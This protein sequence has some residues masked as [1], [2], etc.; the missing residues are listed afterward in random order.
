M[1]DMECLLVVLA[2]QS[3][4]ISIVKNVLK[5]N[6]LFVG[7]MLSNAKLDTTRYIGVASM[8]AVHLELALSL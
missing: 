4:N 1:V 5:L 2:I 8:Q 7:R 6:V 3:A